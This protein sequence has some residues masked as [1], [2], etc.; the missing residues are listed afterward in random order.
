MVLTHRPRYIET[1]RVPKLAEGASSATEPKYPTPTDAKGELAE[2]SKVP[3]TESAE[4]TKRPAEVKEKTVEE[5]ELKKPSGL[6]KILS[7]LPKPELPKLSKAPAI[8]P[9]RRR[10]ASVLDAVLEL[11]RASTPASAKETAEATTTHA[12]VEA[13][14]SVPIETGPVET[15]QSIEQ[16]SLDVSLVLEKED[17]PKKV[18]FPPPE[19]TTSLTIV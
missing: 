19:Q 11:T 15:R 3:A 6:Q 18:E 5:P 9:K 17:T 12:E 4:A 14:P 10:M 16:E 2:V 8:T 13:G 7:P 1:A